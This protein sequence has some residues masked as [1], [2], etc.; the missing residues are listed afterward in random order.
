VSTA[1]DW[2]DDKRH[3]R[4]LLEESKEINKVLAPLVEAGVLDVLPPIHNATVDDVVEAFREHRYRGRTR[5][6]HFGGHA[7]GSK[8]MFEDVVGAQ[9]GAH[10]SG[11][12]GYLGR[13]RGLPVRDQ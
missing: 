8:L 10:A 5:I 3:L 2:V 7:S 13:Q 12:A 1:H 4:N 9:T 6:F 11:L